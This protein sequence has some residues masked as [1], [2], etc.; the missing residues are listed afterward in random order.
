MID[1]VAQLINRHLS[2]GQVTFFT[3]PPRRH[4]AF[5]SLSASLLKP[6]QRPTICGRYFHG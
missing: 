1:R 2:C 4:E 6:K 5:A 3:R